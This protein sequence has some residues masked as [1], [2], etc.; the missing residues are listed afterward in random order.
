MNLLLGLP[1]GIFRM[2]GVIL[3][4]LIRFAPVI[5]VLAFGVY[6][7]RKHQAMSRTHRE[8]DVD[9]G[10]S[11][12][13]DFT[14]PVV[15]VDYREV[16]EEDVSHTPE[17][18]APFAH[19]PGWILV[20]S[21][22][23]K[24][25]CRALSLS[26]CT[27]ANWTA[28]LTAVGPGKW[29]V[30]PPMGDWVLIVAEGGRAVSPEQLADLSRRFHEAQ[31]YV[32]HRDIYAWA[33]YQNGSARRVYA[34]SGGRVVLVEGDWTGEEIALGFGR[35]PRLDGGPR[36]D[37]PD[38]DDVLAIAAAWGIDPLLEDNP[39]PPGLGWICTP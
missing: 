15:T 4:T 34:I 20:R 6:L 23:P 13:P 29:F 32:A 33:D 9:T 5:L 17:K 37:F 30:S 36:E 8:E 14:G 18:P 26:S 1:L 16:R 11:A 28:G 3:M 21:H 27:A 35:F 31:A 39:Y 38:A 22:D 24:A 19:K 12:S 25:V 7:W 10:N 2:L